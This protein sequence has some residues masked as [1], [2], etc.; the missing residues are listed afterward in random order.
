MALG[1]TACSKKIVAAFESSDFTKTFFHGHSYTANP[2]A[3]AA[4]NASFE[5]LMKEGMPVHR[6][7]MISKLH[8]TFRIA[9]TG[10]R[11]RSKK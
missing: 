1:V 9:R 2:I 8:E 3:C 10:A 6:L 11:E 4:A 7:D 5:L